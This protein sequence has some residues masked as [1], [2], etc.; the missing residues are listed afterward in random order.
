MPKTTYPEFS[1]EVARERW[2]NFRQ[3][4]RQGS[5]VAGGYSLA[6]TIALLI[7]GR[8]LIRL[9][10]GEEFLPAYPALL[11]LLV[12]YLVANTVFWRRPAL[13]A[14]GR[15]DFPT[16]VNVILAVLKILGVILI[17]PRY[18]Y[19]A[20]AALLA[21]FYILNSLISYWRVITI[22]NQKEKPV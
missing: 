12:G 8:P 11:I 19:L 3:I 15:P 20:A 6:A 21:G 7:L 1:R 9:I 10:Y 22:M 5:Y 16:K 13:L 17:V 2:D 4:M 18:G 14:L